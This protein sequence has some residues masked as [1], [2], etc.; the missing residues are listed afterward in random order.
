MLEDLCMKPCPPAYKGGRQ[1]RLWLAPYKHGRL[2]W[3]AVWPTFAAGEVSFDENWAKGWICGKD[4]AA[5]QVTNY[6]S[7]A[8]CGTMQLTQP[9]SCGAWL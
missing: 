8:L 1:G 5:I 7:N 6:Y 2:K 9:M 3:D 4:S